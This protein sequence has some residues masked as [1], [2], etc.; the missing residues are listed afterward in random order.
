MHSQVLVIH[1]K[2]IPLEDVMYYY[3]EI[4]KTPIDAMSD[5]RCNFILE[6]DELGITSILNKIKKYL[7]TKL[8][9]YTEMLQYRSKHSLESFEK[10]YKRRFNR[11]FEYYVYLQR[12]LDTYHK[13]K[14]LSYDNPSQI[15]FIKEHG[16]WIDDSR[17][18]DVYI[19]GVGYGIFLNPYQLW[20]YYKI[21]DERRFPEGTYFLISKNDNKS[22]IMDFYELDIDK[23]VENINYFTNVWEYIIFCENT[24]EDSKLYTTDKIR[25]GDDYNKECLTKNLKDM[26]KYLQSKYAE[27]DKY[28]V[29]AI[30]FHW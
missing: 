4:D 14:N 27:K 20:D 11:V 7:E 2:D 19:K 30:D 5:E 8:K 24:P 1:P 13:I 29:T 9:Q 15:K 22:N 16:Y 21:V 18:T 25:F 23:T 17:M 10:K 12:E 28:T 3:Q 6:I 26:L